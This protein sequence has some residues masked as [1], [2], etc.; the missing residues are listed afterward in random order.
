MT[1]C[2]GIGTKT[3]QSFGFSQTIEH[4]HSEKPKDSNYSNLWLLGFAI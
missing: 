1:M 4:S 2:K 3:L